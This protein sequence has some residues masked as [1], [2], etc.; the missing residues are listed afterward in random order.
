MLS[1]KVWFKNLYNQTEVK[2]TIENT[3]TNVFSNSSK[4]A[5]I[6]VFFNVI[7]PNLTYDKTL[8][9]N[10]LNESLQ[11]VS[12]NRGVVEKETLI[13]SKGEIVN[14]N[15]FQILNSL[16][17]EYESKDWTKSNYYWIVSIYNSIIAQHSN[18]INI[19]YFF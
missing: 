14:D 8:T 7:K 2:S 6:A 17:K 16:S 12:I 19:K 5:L 11:T 9:E 15:K 3:L 10:V 1:Q 18:A 13:I 4:N